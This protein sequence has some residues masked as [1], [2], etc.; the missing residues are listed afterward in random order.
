MGGVAVLDR[1]TGKELSVAGDPNRDM[2]G[3]R[4][5]ASIT[6]FLYSF[7][8]VFTSYS[9]ESP[10]VRSIQRCSGRSVDGLPT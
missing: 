9:G 7:D 1:R 8:F 10:M 4:R 6:S 2:V 5:F 3:E